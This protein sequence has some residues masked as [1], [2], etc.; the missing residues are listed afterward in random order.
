MLRVERL[1]TAAATLSAVLSS[2]FPTSARPPDHLGSA[3]MLA[4]LLHVLVVLVV[5]NAPGGDAKPGEGVWGPITV[6]LQGDRFEKGSGEPA[7][8]RRDSA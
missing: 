3:L 6:R 1:L 7:R 8:P 2:P 4:V 5:G